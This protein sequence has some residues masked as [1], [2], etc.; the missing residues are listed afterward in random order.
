MNVD[1]T[2]GGTGLRRMFAGSTT[3]APSCVKALLLT[4]E[5]PRFADGA[6]QA[7]ADEDS[8]RAAE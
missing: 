3:T 6:Q 2:G 8:G 5:M 4:V 7:K 1:T